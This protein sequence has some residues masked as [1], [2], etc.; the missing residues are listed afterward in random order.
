MSLRT[1]LTDSIKTAMKAHDT[2]ALD[3]LRY[4]LSLIKNVEIDTKK[5]LTDEEIISL[6]QKEVK[7]RREAIDQFKTAGRQELVE[8]E[9]QQLV[10][11][12]PFLPKQLSVEEV[13]IEVKSLIDALPNKDMSTAMR[14]IMPKFKG[15]AD[16]KLVSDLVKKLLA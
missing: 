6:L 14:E 12:L 13:E 7:K 16:G 1:Q 11:L 4:L 5:E 15:R 9:E 2:I 3:A 10:I 8:K